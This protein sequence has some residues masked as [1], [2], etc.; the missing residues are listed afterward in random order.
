MAT[1]HL[2]DKVSKKIDERFHFNSYTESMAGNAYEF[3]GV[4]KIKI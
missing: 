1:V 3:E 4:K 2:A